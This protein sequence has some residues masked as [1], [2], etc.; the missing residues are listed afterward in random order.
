MRFVDKPVAQMVHTIDQLGQGI[1]DNKVLTFVL[2]RLNRCRCFRSRENTLADYLFPTAGREI[3]VLFRPG[4][5]KFLFDDF[6]GQDKPAVFISCFQD[7]LERSQGIEPRQ[8]WRFQPIAARIK[9]HRAW[10]GQNAD[11]MRRPDRIPIAN[12]FRIVPHPVAVDHM[13]SG[14]FTDAIIRPST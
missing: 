4:Q 3:R 12:T 2:E 8:A 13:P 10:P 11:P 9:P 7:F 6:L 5:G 14:F 1:G